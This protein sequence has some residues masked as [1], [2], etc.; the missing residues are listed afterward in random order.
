MELRGWQVHELSSD[1][2]A[3]QVVPGKGGD[4]LSAQ[5]RATGDELLW[6][7]PWGLRA[8]GSLP[9]AGSSVAPIIEAYPGGWQTVFPNGGSPCVE[10][11]AEWGMHG[12]AWTAPWDVISADSAQLTMTTRLVRSPFE[13][14][15]RVAVAGGRLSVT[16]AVHNIGRRPVEVMW[17]H[18]PAFGP[19][20][21]GPETTITT[22]ARRFVTDDARDTPLGDLEPGGSGAWPTAR[23]RDGSTVDVSRLPAH[24]ETVERFG[25][26]TDF[27][28]PAWVE[29]TNQS[30]GLVGRLSWDAAV[31]PHAWYWL[32]AHGTM[33]F[34]WFGAVYVFAIEPA[35]SW[36]GQ[37][38]AAVR[39]KTQTQVVFAADERREV[40]VTLDV[41]GSS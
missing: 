27:D 32:E 40:T 19:G 30:T 26:L 18:H 6:Q 10:D 9:T 39:E 3:V 41:S 16:E 4:V 20:L 15:K 17:S 8:R 13:L 14:T 36:P 38:I 24:D 33:D 1:E 11:G 37:G 34:P 2:L 12:E 22:S 35:T 25:Y 5:W 21:A 7:S 28:G 29:L 23:R 31:L